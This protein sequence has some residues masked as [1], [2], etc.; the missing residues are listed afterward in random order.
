MF[1]MEKSLSKEDLEAA[2]A[3]NIRKTPKSTGKGDEAL[4]EEK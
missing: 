1:E 4:V 3:S 2:Y